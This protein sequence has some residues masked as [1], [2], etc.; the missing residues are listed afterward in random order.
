MNKGD[1]YLEKSPAA[2]YVALL[3]AAGVGSRLPGR[4]LSKELLPFG[5]NHQDGRPIISHVLSCI[6]QAGID[7]VIIVLRHGKRDIA[8]R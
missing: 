4:L 7:N 2:E 6:Q 3:P 8:G 1:Q 5:N